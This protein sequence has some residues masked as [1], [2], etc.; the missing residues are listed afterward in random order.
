MKKLYGKRKQGVFG[1]V[2]FYSSQYELLEEFQRETSL[3]ISYLVR[4][5][6]DF[7]KEKELIQD[8][9]EYLKV[10]QKDRR[11]IVEP[12]GEEHD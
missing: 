8:F 4:A 2:Y 9:R 12:E 7:I 10:K 5:L 6:I 11:N 1:T 3:S